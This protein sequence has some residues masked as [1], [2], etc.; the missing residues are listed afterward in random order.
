MLAR[1]ELFDHLVGA[2][3]RGG[4]LLSGVGYMP[5]PWQPLNVL[6]AAEQALHQFSR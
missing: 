3:E 4:E 2:G 5:R 1:A 6:I